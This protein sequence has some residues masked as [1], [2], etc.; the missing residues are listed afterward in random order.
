V[1]PRKTLNACKNIY[2]FCAGIRA[3]EDWKI[4]CF[5]GEDKDVYNPN[6]QKTIRYFVS[7]KGCKLIKEQKSVVSE[8]F[9][10]KDSKERVTKSYKK[11]D[12]IV[13]QIKVEASKVLEQ[14]AIKINPKTKFEDY[15]IDY[16]FYLNIINKEI[17]A[18]D[19]QL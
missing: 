9:E 13:K 2:D 16:N 18:V 11:G 17:E 8:S 3:K 14:V 6:T 1:P 5:S 4:I 19:P 7:R 15:N 12:V 10:V